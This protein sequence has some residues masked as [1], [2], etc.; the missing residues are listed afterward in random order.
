MANR[1]FP[2]AGKIYSL[3]V[4]PVM[5]DCRILIGASGV[6][7]S[8]KGAGIKA[9]TKAS[10]GRYQIQFQDNYNR[11]FSMFSSVAAPV[12]G[13]ALSTKTA[14]AA[15]SVGT[16]YQIVALGTTTAANWLALGLPA[17]VT[18]AVGQSFVA[19]AT[20]AGT[21]TGTVKAV[22]VSGINGIEIVGDPQAELAP[23]G[24]INQGGYIMVQAVGATDASTTTQIPKNPADGSYLNLAFML[25]NS[26]VIVPNE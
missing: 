25:S 1:N 10:T 4:M 3:H 19:A 5:L 7:T 26:G 20:G 14:D 6:V 11:F 17:G 22:S 24:T 21:G 16:V 23:V 8:F 9:V 13:S 12:T 18:A 2:S 15:L